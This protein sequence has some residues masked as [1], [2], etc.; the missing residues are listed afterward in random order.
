MI[1]TT[2]CTKVLINNKDD[3]I[4]ELRKPQGRKRYCVLE[5]QEVASLLPKRREVFLLEA[6]VYVRAGTQLENALRSGS[7]PW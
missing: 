6:E 5:K 2:L 7:P 4:E 1:T 3:K